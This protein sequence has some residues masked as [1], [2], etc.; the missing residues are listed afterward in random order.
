MVKKITLPKKDWYK[1]KT[2]WAGVFTALVA[3]LSSMY[4]ETSAI[5]TSLIAIGSALGV[6]GRFVA[7]TE[8]E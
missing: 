2:M 4:G 5:V 3:V 7:T 1:S 6:Y 8:L